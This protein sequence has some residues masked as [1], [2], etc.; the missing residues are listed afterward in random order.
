MPGRGGL[1]IRGA[2]LK[3]QKP[4]LWRRSQQRGVVSDCVPKLNTRGVFRD[5]LRNKLN[6]A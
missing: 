5:V 6:A 3:E 1:W 2:G 4:S